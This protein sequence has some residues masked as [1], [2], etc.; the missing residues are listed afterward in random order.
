MALSVTIEKNVQNCHNFEYFLHLW[1]KWAMNTK[2]Y[3]R[4]QIINPLACVR[5]N[6]LLHCMKNVTMNPALLNENI[7]EKYLESGDVYIIAWVGVMTNR[8]AI[9]GNYDCMY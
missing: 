6:A 3:P 8:Q 2:R 4:I 7:H 9:F 5:S 1:Y